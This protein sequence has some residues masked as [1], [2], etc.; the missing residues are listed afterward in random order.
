MGVGQYGVQKNVYL[1]LSICD[2]G[3]IFHTGNVCVLMCVWFVLVEWTVT[4]EATPR[5]IHVS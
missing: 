4:D 3:R 1:L 2:F 5:S